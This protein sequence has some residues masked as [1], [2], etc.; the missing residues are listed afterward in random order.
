MSLVPTFAWVGT[1]VRGE[2]DQLNSLSLLCKTVERGRKVGRS[3]ESAV[4]CSMSSCKGKR[5]REDSSKPPSYSQSRVGGNKERV[6]E[7]VLC[8]SKDKFF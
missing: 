3:Y 1:D 6:S 4:L 8:V 2:P 7:N 5:T